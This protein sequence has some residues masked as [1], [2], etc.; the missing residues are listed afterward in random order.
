MFEWFNININYNYNNNSYIVLV[1]KK[2]SHLGSH[3]GNIAVLLNLY[4]G[5]LKL[6]S[7]CV[8]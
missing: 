8:L 2:S 7:F 3:F 6:K 4:S 5:D 1:P